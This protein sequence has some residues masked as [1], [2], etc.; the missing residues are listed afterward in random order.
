M[1]A[2]DSERKFYPKVESLRG[3]AEQPWNNF[4]RNISKSFNVRK[5]IS[6]AFVASA[7]SALDA[8]TLSPTS[9]IDTPT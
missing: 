9:R 8:Q 6:T 2:A 4:H 5:T 1:I 7:R 3:V